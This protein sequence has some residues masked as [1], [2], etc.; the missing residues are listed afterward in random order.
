MPPGGSRLP[1]MSGGVDGILGSQDGVGDELGP[2]AGM[3]MAAAS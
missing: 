3:P 1:P 2:G